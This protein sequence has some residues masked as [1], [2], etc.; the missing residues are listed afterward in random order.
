MDDVEC[1]KLYANLEICQNDQ[2]W[3]DASA[4][5]RASYLPHHLR[6]L[7][8]FILVFYRLSNATQLRQKYQDLLTEEFCE[9]YEKKIKMKHI[10]GYSQYLK[11]FSSYHIKYSNIYEEKSASSVQFV[12]ADYIAAASVYIGREYVAEIKYDAIKLPE[13]LQTDCLKTKS[14]F[15]K[16][17][18]LAQ[19]QSNAFRC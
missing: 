14:L 10:L 13:T 7:F 2:H 6:P 1:I 4:E 5:S 12:L 18:S 8:S 17:M 16:F 11:L 9:T 3:D 15:K 19:Y